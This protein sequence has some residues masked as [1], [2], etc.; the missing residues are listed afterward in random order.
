MLLG[1]LT[2]NLPKEPLQLQDLMTNGDFLMHEDLGNSPGG[3]A[4]TTSHTI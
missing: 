4:L 2:Q 3:P 1:R